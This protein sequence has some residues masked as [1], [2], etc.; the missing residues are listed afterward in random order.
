ML[1]PNDFVS[2]PEHS[3]G[4]GLSPLQKCQSAY[5]TALGLIIIG[6]GIWKKQAQSEYQIGIHIHK[7]IF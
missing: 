6:A 5:S 4:K 7:H 3:V 2:N 1:Q